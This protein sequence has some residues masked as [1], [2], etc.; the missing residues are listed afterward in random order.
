MNTP[1]FP[2]TIFEG[3]EGNFS[4]VSANIWQGLQSVFGQ[5]LGTNL[6]EAFETLLKAV[7][8]NIHW[9]C[10]FL[11]G[12]GREVKKSLTT[13]SWETVEHHLGIC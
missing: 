10:V 11:A 6:F 2:R 5:L 7:F 3:N 8:L 12:P 9:S 13:T 1:S 4:G